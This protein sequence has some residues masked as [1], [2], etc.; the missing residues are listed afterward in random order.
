MDGS[1]SD[2]RPT[3]RRRISADP[4]PRLTHQLDLTSAALS[5][6]QEDQLDKLMNLIQNR[7][8]IVV[9]AGAGI[10]VSAGSKCLLDWSDKI[11]H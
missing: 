9:V 3:K 4:K 11:G 5:D 8:K 1:T 7:R 10:S 2:E 6:G